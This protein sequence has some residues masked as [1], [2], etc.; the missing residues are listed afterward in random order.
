[1]SVSPEPATRRP[2][3]SV[4]PPV[5]LSIP[6]DKDYVVLVRSAV[7]HLGARI[8]LTMEELGD[9]R[10]AVSEACAL[11]LL[12]DEIDA[13]GATLD[14]RFAEADGALHVAVAADAEPGAGPQLGG[15]GWNLLSALVDELRWS[16]DGGRAEVSLVKRPAARGR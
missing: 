9:L 16:N 7:G 6:A 12:P 11:L 8:G 1:M 13:T 2:G 5:L 4:P 14:C 10:L 15:F 3:A